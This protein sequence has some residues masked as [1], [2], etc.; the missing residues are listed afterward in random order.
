MITYNGYLKISEVTKC[1]PRRTLRS[2][3]LLGNWKPFKNAFYFTLKA[4]FVHKIF[5]FKSWLL[6]HVA[7]RFDKKDKVTFKFYDITA[8]LTNSRN[9]YNAQ[10]CQK[11]MQ[12][13]NDQLIE[14]K[15][16]A[17]PW[18]QPLSQWF[19]TS[20]NYLIY[21]TVNLQF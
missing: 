20:L 10:C 3:I 14:S 1:I 8:W 18:R 5:R 16:R 6:G 19:F 17:S 4:L 21:K 2:E 15:G 13:G 11:K 7:K 9:T 12:S